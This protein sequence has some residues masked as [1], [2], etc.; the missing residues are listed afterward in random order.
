MN[1][2]LGKLADSIN[3]NNICFIGVP[4]EEDRENGVE[5]LIKEILV[6][7]F[8]N[9]GNK[10]DIQIQEARVQPSKSTKA[11]KHQEKF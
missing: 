4:E 2:D 5:N 9:L 11:G 7:K 10:T 3:H 1:V 6:E 8:T